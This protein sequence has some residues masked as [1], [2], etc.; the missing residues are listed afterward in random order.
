MLDFLQ[1]LHILSR[2]H[3]GSFLGDN[4]EGLEDLFGL[5]RMQT[6]RVTKMI[7]KIFCKV[8]P[9]S[10]HV[11]KELFASRVF[12]NIVGGIILDSV[13]DEMVFFLIR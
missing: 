2:D 10:F 12:V 1:Y 8:F 13:V 11:V 4:W 9:F 7:L 6:P 5:F 3:R